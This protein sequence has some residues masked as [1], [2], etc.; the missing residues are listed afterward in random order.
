MWRVVLLPISATIGA[1]QYV[2]MIYAHLSIDRMV[3]AVAVGE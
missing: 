1:A 2:K 3:D